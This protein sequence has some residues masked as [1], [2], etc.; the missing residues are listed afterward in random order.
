MIN[1][2]T[3]I[4]YLWKRIHILIFLSAFL[5][6]QISFSQTE[7]K[8]GFVILQEQDTLNG[9]VNDKEGIGQ[10]STC[11]FRNSEDG[12]TIEYNPKDILGYGVRG[13]SLYLSRSVPLDVIPDDSVFV[14]VMVFGEL[15]LFKYRSYFFVNKNNGKLQYLK[16]TRETYVLYGKKRFK[17]KKEFLGL[18][19][20]L[21]Q[22][23]EKV[24]SKLK[25]TKLRT[26][27][28]TDI[29][30][31]YNSCRGW[32]PETF[33]DELPWTRFNYMLNGGYAFSSIEF[34]SDLAKDFYLTGDWTN[35][36]SFVAGAAVDISSPRI[37]ESLFIHIGAFYSESYYVLD[38]VR[39]GAIIREYNF[40]EIDLK[41][42]NIPV[43]LKYEL[44]QKKWVPYIGVGINYI[45]HLD[46][47][48][49]REFE[50]QYGSS[51]DFLIPEPTEFSKSQMGFWVG[52]GV[53][54]P[55]FNEYRGFV[56]FR[57][58][59]TNGITREELNIGSNITNYS[60]FI[61]LRK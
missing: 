35:G 16:N 28:L 29:V 27:S 8:P 53:Y 9:W 2:E 14:E 26:R 36:N 33:K 24:R 25:N 20:F 18:L 43:G 38:D 39:G 34:S 17:E 6:V 19:S 22:D 41:K 51:V 37:Y 7:F 15:S 21:M 1:A 59:R 60:L 5:H 55:L 49:Y 44:F 52:P 42:I 31:E 32:S 13:R 3:I 11:E 23:C 47:S 10:Y 46:Q 61:G 57:Y 48:F 50:R 54:F 12:Q 40:A 45:H 4:L 30:E 56:E 58:E